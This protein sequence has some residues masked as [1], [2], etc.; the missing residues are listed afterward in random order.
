MKGHADIKFRLLIGE[1][2]FPLSGFCHP[3]RCST[4][5]LF[6]I[7]SS[8]FFLSEQIPS[9]GLLH[10]C[11]CRC[12]Q[13]ILKRRSKFPSFGAL[14]TWAA[15]ASRW[16]VARPIVATFSGVASR[17]FG[18]FDDISRKLPLVAIFLQHRSRL[19]LDLD[20]DFAIHLSGDKRTQINS[21]KFLLVLSTG[22]AQV[23]GYGLERPGFESNCRTNPFIEKRK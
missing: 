16:S 22:V 13:T 5:A 4:A 23:V 20:L 19:D 21:F 7:G 9:L 14:D 2:D 3:W 12:S 17:R 15:A 11:A 6:V 18:S 8:L 10:I 1:H